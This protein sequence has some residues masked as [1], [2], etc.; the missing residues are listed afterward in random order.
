MEARLV[1]LY[2][3]ESE[4]EILDRQVDCKLTAVVASFIH[5]VLLWQSLL[6]ELGRGYEV[7][8]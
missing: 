6:D 8:L 5:G 2:K 7:P 1:S 3:S 4:Y